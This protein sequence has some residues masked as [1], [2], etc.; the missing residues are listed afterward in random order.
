MV[1]VVFDGYDK[2]PSTKDHKQ[3]SQCIAIRHAAFLANAFNKQ[4]FVHLLVGCFTV[5]GHEVLQAVDDADIVIV[6]KF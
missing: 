4:A 3:A 5:V 1:I 2:S 6:S